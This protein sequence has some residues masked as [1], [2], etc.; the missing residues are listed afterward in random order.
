MIG[1]AIGNAYGQQKMKMILNEL[2]KK[3]TDGLT[4]LASAEKKG[5]SADR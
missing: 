5:E 3:M 4:N 1:F 2:L